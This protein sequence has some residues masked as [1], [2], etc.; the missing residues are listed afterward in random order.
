[1]DA[2]PSSVLRPEL[3]REIPCSAGLRVPPD[4]RLAVAR[5][6]AHAADSAAD[7]D[8]DNQSA[9]RRFAHPLN[10]DIRSRMTLHA[11][12][13]G[14]RALTVGAAA[15]SILVATLTFA[16]TQA[17]AAYTAQVKAGT[18]QIRGDGASDKLTL[19]PTPTTLI[20]DVGDD[21]TADFTFD[22]SAFTAVS[23]Q[24]GDGDDE[25][26]VINSAT[27]IDMTIDGGAGDDTLIGA[28][29][30]ETLLGGSGNDFVDGNIGADTARLGSGND[31]FEWD[32]GDGSDSVDGQGG[33]DA[34]AFNGSNI[35]EE[36][37]VTGNTLTRNVAAITMSFAGLENVNVRPLGG[38]DN[39]T[40][41]GTDGDDELDL[42]ANTIDA[43]GLKVSIVDPEPTD[44]LIA[45]G[46]AGDDS[47]TWTGTSGDDQLSF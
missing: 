11:D 1:M 26:R 29:G 32:P 3:L 9:P 42:S 39:V 2:R 10:Y 25:V 36:I 17:D 30:N 8:A 14:R 34:L 4:R 15:G 5:G 41:D 38:V 23:V 31:T 37:H 47:A 7:A 12:R 21:G 27:P 6:G 44:R 22:R 43:D 13:I 20:L 33:T 46:G 40:V 16:A 19:A 45:D 24:A 18:L 28:N 35:G